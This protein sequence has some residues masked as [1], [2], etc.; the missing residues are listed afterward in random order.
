MRLPPMDEIEITTTPP[1]ERRLALRVPVRRPVRVAVGLRAFEAQLMDLSITGCRLH[2]PEPITAHGSVW[3]VMPAGLGG[4]FPLPIRG[5]V[6]RAESVRGEPTGVCEVALRF[7]EMSSRV[8]ERLAAAVSEILNPPAEAGSERRRSLRHWFGRR[9]IARGAGRPRVLI[10]RDLS[11]GG[12]RVENAAGL[13]VGDELEL[14]LHSQVGGVPFVVRARVLRTAESGEAA[15][16]FAE[17]SAGQRLA[18]DKLL[19]EL[20]TGGGPAVVSEVLEPAP[21]LADQG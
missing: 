1:T 8:Y 20:G 9:V 21:R 3:V 2:C 4:R 7:R 12:M 5:E 10:G 11:A 17:L 13:E 18:L 16:A 19:F 14:A 6:A 15:L